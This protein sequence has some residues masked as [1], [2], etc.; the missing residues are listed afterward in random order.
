MEE[1]PEENPAESADRLGR[2]CDV[3][4]IHDFSSAYRI[5]SKCSTISVSVPWDSQGGSVQ[6]Y[7]VEWEP[8][9]RSLAEADGYKISSSFVHT[10][11][12]RLDTPIIV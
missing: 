12:H 8:L 9:I 10:G 3:S 1:E 11:Q 7:N 4:S 6:A 2:D 5:P